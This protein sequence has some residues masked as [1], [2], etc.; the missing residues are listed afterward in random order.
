MRHAL[1][2]SSSDLQ[3]KQSGNQY[4]AVGRACTAASA[5]ADVQALPIPRN[6]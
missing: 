3:I 6:L 1:K 5:P 4:R 2:L